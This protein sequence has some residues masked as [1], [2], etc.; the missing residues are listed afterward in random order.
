MTQHELNR[1]VATQTGETVQ[2]IKTMGFSPL[3]ER[4]PIEERQEP[5]VV[6]WDEVERSRY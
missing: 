1:E 6:D 2:T 5:L 3:R 4:I